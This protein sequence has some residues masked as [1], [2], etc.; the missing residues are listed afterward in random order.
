MKF[1]YLPILII[2]FCFLSLGN[3]IPKIIEPIEICSPQNNTFIGGEELTYKIYYNW[4]FVWLS[5]GEVVFKVIDQGDSYKFTARGKTYSSYD[6][7]FKADDNF[8]SIV[9]KSTLL[10]HSFKRDIKEN[11]YRY[12]E[13]V[14]FDASGNQIRSWTGKSEQTAKLTNHT[15]TGCWRDILAMIYAVRVQNFESI[16]TGSQI[17]IH[18]FLDNK[19]YSLNLQYYG[20]RDEKRI[21]TLGKQSTYHLSPETIAGT[22]F[23]EKDRMNIWASTDQ[24][25]LPLL[26]E[27]PVSVG[28]VKAI[29]I[30][31]KGL[32][33]SSTVLEK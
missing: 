33:Y 27:S 21:H 6:W 15:M 29:L 9:D 16:K 1:T 24:N 26:I 11:K 31:H 13:K 17:P 19:N 20:K 5:A 23:K 3:D 32:K 22:V 8:E 7:F 10:P 12:Y 2:P 4:N 18:V 14:E 28:S 25:K 30:R